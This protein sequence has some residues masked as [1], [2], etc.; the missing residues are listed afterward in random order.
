MQPRRQHLIDTAY[1]LFNEHGYHATGIDWI[2]AESSVSKAT[3]Y[4]YFRSKEELILAVLQ[5]RHQQVIE[6]I[7]SY[8]E[9]A[10]ATGETPTLAIF[11]ALN[12]WFK[13]EVFFGCNFINASAEYAAQGD[14]IREF[15]KA[16]KASI[17]QLILDSLIIAN[18]KTR[19]QTA[20]EIALL[21]EGAIVFA[22]T[23]GEKNAALVAKRVASV[24]LGVGH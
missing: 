15:S 11:D 13:S 21:V 4:K 14:P 5:Q 18:K 17:R 9:K 24:L 19:Q 1:R 3:L 22:H 20:D 12:V 7:I 16:H 10:K 23:S 2:L 6:L 8:M